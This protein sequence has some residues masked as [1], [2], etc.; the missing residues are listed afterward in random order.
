MVSR[1]YQNYQRVDVS[2]A[3][4]VR[5]VVMLYEG[6]IKN[7]NQAILLF[8]ANALDASAKITRTLDI[9]NY[10]ASALDHEKGGEI[11]MNLERLYDYMRDTL[12]FANIHKDKEKLA[13]VIGLMQT[14]L[15]GWR[16]IVNYQA[17]TGNGLAEQ[18]AGQP[19]PMQSAASGNLP[20]GLSMVG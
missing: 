8:D 12:A 15:E 9:I 18:T 2:T 11:S 4:P 7:L 13:Q 10:L 19:E 3:D 1:G 20:S 14:L 6:A 16:A 5:I 17:E